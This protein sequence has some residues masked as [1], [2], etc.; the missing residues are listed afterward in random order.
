MAI[1]NIW[2]HDNEADFFLTLFVVEIKEYFHSRPSEDLLSFDSKM[3][4]LENK[5]EIVNIRV[6]SVVDVIKEDSLLSWS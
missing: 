6:I 4:W 3:K 5:W 1:F 2:I